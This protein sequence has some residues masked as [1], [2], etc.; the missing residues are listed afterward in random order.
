MIS[1]I[2]SD[3]F[4]EELHIRRWM[5]CSQ[6]SSVRSTV[7]RIL[8]N[9]LPPMSVLNRLQQFF[10]CQSPSRVWYFP[11]SSLSFCPCVPCV[12]PG[13]SVDLTMQHCCPHPVNDSHHIPSS[14]NVVCVVALVASKPFVRTEMPTEMPTEMLSG[15]F[16][17]SQ[18][19]KR[20]Y[21]IVHSI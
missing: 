6:S 5:F 20:W 3:Y 21:I 2:A 17:V 1:G 8:H 19:V 15:V 16:Q 18:L 14:N 13:C 10:H 12:V 11:T 4:Q 9:S 7:D